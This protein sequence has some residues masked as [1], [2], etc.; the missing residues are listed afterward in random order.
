MWGAC[1]FAAAV[2][3]ASDLSERH[4]PTDPPVPTLRAQATRGL[5]RVRGRVAAALFPT[6]AGKDL[7]VSQAHLLVRE[8]RAPSCSSDN[9]SRWEFAPFKI[10]LRPT[11]LAVE[12]P[13]LLPA[14]SVTPPAAHRP[15]PRQRGQ[16]G[17][18]VEVLVGPNAAARLFAGIPAAE[19]AAGAPPRGE[20]SQSASGGGGGEVGGGFF[21]PDC[22]MESVLGGC[23]ASAAVVAL[24]AGLAK[25]CGETFELHLYCTLAHDA[26]GYIVS[27]SRC[28]HLLGL[29]PCAGRVDGA[30]SACMGGSLSAQVGPHPL[31]VGRS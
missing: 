29:S 11:E 17:V 15:R 13:A 5:V 2:A 12:T 14:L 25:D 19:L 26:N 27:H 1:C 31:G 6:L 4:C 22:D 10:Y 28:F 18:R 3:S 9:F 8:V 20:P 21:H 16:D 30:D 23:A 7:T 24:A